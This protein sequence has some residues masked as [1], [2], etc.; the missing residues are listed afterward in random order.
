MLFAPII[1]DQSVL[2]PMAIVEDLPTTTA[3]FLTSDYT[4]DATTSLI[5]DTFGSSTPE[6][7]KISLCE[8]GDRQFSD[9][10]SVLE[11]STSDFG[12]YQ[13]HDSWDDKAKELGLDY[14]HSFT[15]NLA[16]AKI[17]LDAQGFNAW[18]CH[19]IVDRNADQD[20]GR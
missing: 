17:V 3:D 6:M 15:D 19:A 18:S 4:E 8:S 13:I 20:T 14:K 12:Y 5:W 7:M 9:D 1:I 16:M 10:G 2:A 11:S